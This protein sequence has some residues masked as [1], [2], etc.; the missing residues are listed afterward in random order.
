MLITIICK[1]VILSA[2]ID[3]ANTY[4][5]REEKK[6]QKNKDLTLGRHQ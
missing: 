6:I 5:K 3:D 1:S 2:I 4:I